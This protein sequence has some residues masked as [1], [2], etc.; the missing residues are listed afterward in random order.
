MTSKLDSRFV[1]PAAPRPDHHRRRR[2]AVAVHNEVTARSA[3]AVS[4][5]QQAIDEIRSSQKSPPAAY[6]DV[7]AATVVAR[8][9]AF[10]EELEEVH[11]RGGVRVPNT[12]V[13][14][15]STFLSGLP[16]H[17]PAS[18]PVRTRIAYVMEDLFNLQDYALDL[19]VRGRSS[20]RSLDEVLEWPSERAQ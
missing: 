13:G 15:L 4:P 2:E 18:F 14:R 9:D 1:S 10:L 17:W 8:V 20:M 19:K 16:R 6:R 3:F 11:L 5:L 7:G 12:L